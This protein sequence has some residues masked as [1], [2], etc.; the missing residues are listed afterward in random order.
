MDDL[1]LFDDEKQE[2]GHL[3]D[4]DILEVDRPGSD[5]RATR[6]LSCLG[7]NQQQLDRITRYLE[8]QP[9]EKRC[10][11]L[12]RFDGLVREVMKETGSLTAQ[13][14]VAVR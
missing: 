12:K 6:I 7:I 1:D 14:V 9:I 13:I 4:E 5:A 11:V 8:N 10:E 3:K 2:E